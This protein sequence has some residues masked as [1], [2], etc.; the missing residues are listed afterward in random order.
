MC[1]GEKAEDMSSSSGPASPRRQADVDPILRNALRFTISAREETLLRQYLSG[2]T[3]LVKDVPPE[4]N[5]RKSKTSNEEDYNMATA[6][7]AVRLFAA[8]FSGLTVWEL[9]SKRFFRS[10]AAR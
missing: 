4:L 6:R 10:K 1:V 5:K 7:V 2:K 8:S 9:I 3:S